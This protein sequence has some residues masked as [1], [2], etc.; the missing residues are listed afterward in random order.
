MII[1]I[2]NSS[3][4][5]ICFI[6]TINIVIPRISESQIIAAAII[7]AGKTEHI[8]MKFRG[9]ES[10]R[11]ILKQ[12]SARLGKRFLVAKEEIVSDYDD[13]EDWYEKYTRPGG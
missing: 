10:A 7:K 3:R 8:L 9:D 13:V 4:R 1:R 2:A 6:N 12:F 11:D 5:H